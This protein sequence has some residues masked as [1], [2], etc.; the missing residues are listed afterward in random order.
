MVWYNF[1]MKRIFIL[2]FVSFLNF[3]HAEEVDCSL[4]RLQYLK[5]F[6]GLD[7]SCVSDEFCIFDKNDLQKSFCGHGITYN[8]KN[9]KDFLNKIR[10]K[11]NEYYKKC[12][13]DLTNPP[14]AYVPHKAI[15]KEGRCEVIDELSPRNLTNEKT[16]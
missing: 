4:I 13:Q 11:K 5:M 6:S 10:I 12:P 7:R 3:I 16:Q 9:K 8:R 1:L 14:C 15:C 2:T